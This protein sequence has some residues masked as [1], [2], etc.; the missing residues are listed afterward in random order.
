MDKAYYKMY[1]DNP[2]QIYYNASHKEYI[3]S[4][5]FETSC[6]DMIVIHPYKGPSNELIGKKN[7]YS[8][9]SNLW[10]RFLLNIV[11]EFK[12][13]VQGLVCL[14]KPQF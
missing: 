6:N 2:N 5:E 1:Y 10:K 13:K 3:K 11:H 9:I 7:K 12:N 14:V 4:S 8:V